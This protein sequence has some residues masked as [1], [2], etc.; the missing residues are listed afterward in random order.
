MAQS[1]HPKRAHERPL[2]GVKRTS[3]EGC[4]MSAYDPKQTSAAQI[5][6]MHNG[7]GHGILR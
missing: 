4:E 6:V 7:S 1:G 2:S 5:A 3:T